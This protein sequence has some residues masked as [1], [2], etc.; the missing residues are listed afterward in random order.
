[1]APLFV[2]DKISEVPEHMKQYRQETGRKENKNSRK[3]LGVMKA[4]RILL[5]TPLLKWY[6]EHGLKVTA[7]HQLL[8]YTPG[9][10]FDWF[11]EEVAEARRQADKHDDKKITGETSKLKGNSFYGKMIE[12][13]TKHCYTTFTTD[14]NRVDTALRSP[15]FEDLEE[16][17][18]AYEV[19]ERKR[20][21][22]ITR[23]YQCGIAVY[24]LAKLRML[25]FYYDFWI[26]TLIGE[27]LSIS[28]WIRILLILRYLVNAC[29]ML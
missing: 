19:Q 13:I 12:D 24:Q 18:D 20:K 26:S 1:M 2:V 14:E 3:L 21:A 6:I 9:W 27:T 25:E 8:Q 28:T 17:G 4:K 22:E 10:P 23:P 29:E 5:Y 16:I 7:Y 15:F 11:P